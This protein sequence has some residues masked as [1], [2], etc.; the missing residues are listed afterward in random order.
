MMAAHCFINNRTKMCPPL[1]L[2]ALILLATLSTSSAAKQYRNHTFIFEASQTDLLV[3]YGPKPK[4]AG[5]PNDYDL[6]YI[7]DAQSIQPDDIFGCVHIDTVRN[8]RR[9]SIGG[10]V[11]LCWNPYGFV[12]YPYANI[13]NVISVD[14]YELGRMV[15]L[16]FVS[17]S[18]ENTPGT[19]TDPI[20]VF[21]SGTALPDQFKLIKRMS[22]GRFKHSDMSCVV[23]YDGRF[24]NNGG[25][26]PLTVSFRRIIFD[27]NVAWAMDEE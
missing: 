10:N 2:A 26:P 1:L 19:L 18:H 21:S 27:C 22:T 17:G 13:F 5:L 11:E 8:I 15:G 20:Q 25:D 3:N 16:Y 6:E 4:Y 12:Y 24:T 14:F 9:E 7:F 23:F